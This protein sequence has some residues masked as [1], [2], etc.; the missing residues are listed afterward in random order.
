[1]K[2]DDP[3]DFLAARRP[4]SIAA[5]I[6]RDERRKRDAPSSS[7]S[8]VLGSAGAML[9]LAR[10]LAAVTNIVH[11][12]DE[13]YNYW[14]PLHYIMFGYGL[15]TWEYSARYALRSWWYIVLH[16]VI[17]WPLAVLST[18]KVA[19]F[20]FIK[21]IL[22]LCSAY[23]EYLL[24]TALAKRVHPHVA[25]LY[26]VFAVFSS[27]MFVSSNAF[28]PSSL[29]MVAMTLSAAGILEG[30]S[31]M[32]I[33]SAVVGCTWGWIVAG[34]GFAPYAL[35]VL[36]A[37]WFG[38]GRT[39]I[40]RSFGDLC[41]ALI[42][43]LVP[44]VA[45]DRWYYGTWTSSLVNFLK[46]NVKGGGKS[47]LY[48]VEP[49]SFY[50]RNGFNQLQLVLPLALLLPVLLCARL[51][52]RKNPAEAGLAVA[53]S[54]AYLWL[55][56]ITMLPHKEER[57]LYV[58]YPLL[59]AAAAYST[60]RLKELLQ[61]IFPPRLVRVLV[62]AG[63]VGS[64]ALSL[65][66]I[67]ALVHNYG[68]TMTL[69]KHLPTLSSAAD[70][71]IVCAGADWYKYPSSFFLPGTSY[72]LQFVKSSFDGLLPRPFL[73]EPGGTAASP[74]EFNDENRMEEAN[75]WDDAAWCDYFVTS[76]IQA[77]D[78]R[79][80]WQDEAVMQNATWAVRAALPYIHS[81]ASPALF[82]A[83]NVPFLSH[84]KNRWMEYVLLEN[85]M[86]DS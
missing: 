58:V 21:V 65:S 23:A 52:V 16:K 48:G 33:W 80:E 68:S 31:R 20:Y 75:F 63:V 71:T 5:S 78:D 83:F 53:L 61:G 10:T 86:V 66:R 46:Y 50:L 56:A 32:V 84:K 28:L 29:A 38:A 42:M 37:G 34:L 22:G 49:A 12:C 36:V 26:L 14:E 19:I 3:F 35:W 27:G 7:G 57:F 2:L 64:C 45:C 6:M 54:P 60:V 24:C 72:R 17:G 47:D 69:Y 25:K 43:A 4:W 77:D 30:N 13:V 73:E 76:R 11:D 74:L 40:V 55:A 79:W 44:I 81:A 18:N 51:A 1:V 59:I 41:L 9:V 15:Q 82:R 39:S 85:K 70:R 8:P 62:A 67:G